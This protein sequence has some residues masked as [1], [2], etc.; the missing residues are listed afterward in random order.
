MLV[1][2]S[3]ISSSTSIFGDSVTMPIGIAPTAMQK[4][5]HPDG[6]CANARGMRFFILQNKLNVLI[7]TKN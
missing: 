6:E 7:V 3:E 4:M 5:A 1:D 2:V